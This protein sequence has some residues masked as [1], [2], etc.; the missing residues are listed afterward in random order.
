MIQG[1]HGQKHEAVAVGQER[2]EQIPERFRMEKPLGL[3]GQ[4]RVEVER[5][6][7]GA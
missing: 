7:K 6:G 5:K 1:K 2:G 3:S 4:V